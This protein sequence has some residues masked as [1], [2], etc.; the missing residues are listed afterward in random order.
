MGNVCFD[1][2]SKVLCNNYD[3]VYFQPVITDIY[4]GVWSG[5]TV[6][7]SII[8]ST[9]STDIGFVGS[10]IGR[11]YNFSIG[12][13]YKYWCISDM[14]NNSDR[15]IGLITNGL[16]NTVLAYDLYYN[17]Y[18]LSPSPTLGQSITYGKINING[19]TY[20]IYRT[21]LRSSQ[22]EYIVYSF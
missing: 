11:V 20:R 13:Y 19:F 7:D 8:L 22:N 15:L 1:A 17:N 18:Q 4:Y 21:K 6:T 2:S 12:Y 10:T 3:L 16:V 5:Q 9:F 14:P